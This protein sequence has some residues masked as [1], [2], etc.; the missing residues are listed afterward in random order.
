M[1]TVTFFRLWARAPTTRT[2][3]LPFALRFFGTGSCFVPA[4][5]GPVI[6]AG[7]AISSAGVPSATIFPPW[8]PAPGP[9]S[10]T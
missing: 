2:A 4:S 8:T 10:T 7:F 9:M 3:P 1:S 5:H 6:E